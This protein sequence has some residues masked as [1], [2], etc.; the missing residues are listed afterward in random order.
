MIGQGKKSY[1][2]EILKN[3][4]LRGEILKVLRNDQNVERSPINYLEGPRGTRK[5]H[6]DRQERLAK[7]RSI[8]EIKSLCTCTSS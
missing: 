6:I 7:Q 5:K 4:H 1:P 3:E 2:L 8:D